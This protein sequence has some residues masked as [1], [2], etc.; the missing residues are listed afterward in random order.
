[1]AYFIELALVVNR[2]ARGDMPS[3]SRG[4]CGDGEAGSRPRG[5]KTR[6]GAVDEQEFCIEL[7]GVLRI[8][9]KIVGR[10]ARET[11]RLAGLDVHSDDRAAGEV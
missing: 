11:Q 2:R 9:G 1:M 3:A 8:G 6:E 7:L 10:I 4:D 5:R